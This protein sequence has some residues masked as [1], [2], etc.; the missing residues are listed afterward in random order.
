MPVAQEEVREFLSNLPRAAYPM[1]NQ[2]LAYLAKLNEAPRGAVVL[3]SRE[4]PEGRYRSPQHV[5]EAI[6]S[7]RRPPKRS[8]VNR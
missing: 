3:L 7:N 6:G 5:L 2:M 8:R 4:L 1:S